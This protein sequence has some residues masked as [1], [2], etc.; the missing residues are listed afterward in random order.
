[1]IAPKNIR[2]IPSQGAI[3][4][5]EPNKN[6]ITVCKQPQ[7][8]GAHTVIFVLKIHSGVKMVSNY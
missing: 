5:L 3:T 7:F 8:R 6:K 4:R 2:A 1:M